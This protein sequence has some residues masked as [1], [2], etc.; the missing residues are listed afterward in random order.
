MNYLIP[1]DVPTADED[2]LWTRSV[3]LKA[4]IVERLAQQAP[5]AIHFVVVDA[6]RNELQLK[7]SGKK[8]ITVDGKAFTPTLAT[9]PVLVAYSTAAGRPASDY[10]VGGGPYARAL[11]EEIVVPGVEAITMFRAVQ[12]RVQ[13]SIGQQPYL[14]I[15]GIQEVFFAGKVGPGAP[16]PGVSISDNQAFEIERA[17]SRKAMKELLL[18]LKKSGQKPGG[19]FVSP[20]V[21]PTGTTLSFCFKGGDSL[22]R[23]FVA[24]VA[25]QWTLYGNVRFDFGPR[26]SPRQ[27]D[28]AE[29]KYM[30]VSFEEH[31]GNYAFIGT[32]MRKVPKSVTVVSLE[33]IG[34]MS[35]AD[36]NNGKGQSEILHEFGHVLGLIHSWSFPDCEKELN[37]PIVYETFSAAPM[38]WTHETVDA[39]LKP[40]SGPSISRGVFDKNSIMGY[41][42]PTK[43]FKKGKESPCFM[44]TPQQLS[45]QDKLAI[46]GAYP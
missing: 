40:A 46:F 3:D 11:S 4:D 23:R 25:N 24:D 36:I 1:V 30:I 6:C 38:Y 32:D 35:D 43:F 21:W 29:S 27:C 41:S 14:S 37:W 45:L 42:L 44:E 22:R 15:P 18:Q 19:V 33:S 5:K 34:K 28:K 31:N 39:N 20:N 17:S 8:L 7:R 13:K 9:G 2:S 26:E 10:G 12:L 16:V